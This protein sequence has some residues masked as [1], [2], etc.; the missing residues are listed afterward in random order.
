ML[1][2]ANEMDRLGRPQDTTSDFGFFRRISAEF[3]AAVLASN[4]AATHVL[5]QHLARID[6]PRLQRALAAALEIDQCAPAPIKR[7]VKPAGA[8]WK[9][10]PSRSNMRA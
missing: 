7:A 6:S 1:A 5:R 3:C 9:G 8:L 2:I 4:D 10:L